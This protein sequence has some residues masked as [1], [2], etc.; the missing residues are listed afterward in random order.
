MRVLFTTCLNKS[1]VYI[2]APLAWAMRTAG[3]DVRVAIPPD[4]AED[5]AAIGLAAAPIGE[6]MPHLKED[7]AEA[8]PEQKTASD[9]DPLN[10]VKPHQSNYGWE[11]PP[12][13]FV[14]LAEDFF[15][16]LTP[17][18]M[19][20]GLIDYA[21]AWKPDLIIWNT[22]AFAGPIAARVTGAAHAR[23]L[24]GVDAMAQ[25]HA[26]FVEKRDAEG[27]TDPMKTWLGPKLEAHGHTY[28]DEIALGQWTIDPAPQSLFHPKNTGVHYVP[29]R[30]VV[31]N[32]PAIVPD[33]V[34]EPLERKRVCL[35]LGFSHRESH[36]IEA[37]TADLLEAVSDLD[38]E[39]VATFSAK[40]LAS[41]DRLPDNVR[42]VEFVPLGAL[43]PT[44]SAIVHHG[45]TGT[46]GTAIEHGVPQ[47]IVPGTYWHEKW[48]APVSQ[49][50]MLEE[51]GAGIYVGD[52][53]QLTPEKLRS[54]LAK[55]LDDPSYKIAAE[56]L[57]IDQ[58]S[59]PSP[60]EIVPQLERLTAE[61]RK[62]G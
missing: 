34:N 56:R 27:I 33:W 6:L 4:L 10:R 16:M 62:N 51:R 24:W 23:L 40:Q 3:H 58:L 30:Q 22:L 31:F 18:G 50:N 60:N 39:V 17:D 29:M 61:H 14:H 32:G 48:W 41:L 59:V 2:L 45:G 28:D 25:V 11:D 54:D 49:A 15:P 8:E 53:D 55:V 44:C 1:Q 26:K 20:E 19:W 46:F 43:L 7:L 5:V 36:G 52:S 21:K 9:A 42:P 57:R 47:L 12:A 35:T 37:S 13:E 38:V